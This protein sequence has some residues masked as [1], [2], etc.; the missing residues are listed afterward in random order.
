MASKRILLLLSTISLA[1]APVAVAQISPSNI[2][3]G[4]SQQQR[5]SVPGYSQVTWRVLPTQGMG[6]IDQTGLY[7]S[8]S[9]SGNQSDGIVFI[10]GQP[11]NGPMF[12]TV[13][14]LI[15]GYTPP[16]TV[17]PPQPT[18]PVVSTT[19]PA[20]P[21]T[22]APLQ[23]TISLSPGTVNLQP[24]QSTTFTATVQ[25]TYNTLVQWGVSPSVGTL[26]NGIY[27]APSSI[28]SET[29]VTISA[30]SEADSTQVA[31][32][33]II[34][35]PTVVPV[36]IS[37]TPDSTTLA[38]G[39]SAQ[40]TAS[41]SGTTNTAVNWSLTPSMGSISNGLYTAPSN[42]TSQQTVTL[43]AVSQ[44]DPTKTASASLILKPISKP[45]SAPVTI[46]LSPGSAS[47]LGGQSATFTPSVS[48]TTNKAVTWSI[49][50]QVG[51]ITNGIYQAPAI[52]SSQQIVSI[53]AASVADPSE[54][55]TVTVSL[56][57]IA[58][59][60]TPPTV[61]LGAG[62]SSTF[63]ASVVG[64]SNTAVSW[65]VSP[66]IGTVVN[67]VYTAPATVTS[68]QNV[69]ITATSV[70]DTTKTATATVSLA[71]TPP[72]PTNTTVTLP[73]EVL[74]ANGT[75]VS[76][77]VNIPSGS[78]LSGPMSL[79][80]QIHGLRSE[81]QASVQINNS[82]W[83]PISDSTVTMMGNATAFGGIGGGFHT[84]QMTM[85]LPAGTVQA[86]AN[87]VN[88][89]FN[90][91]D[92]RVSG[93]RVLAFNIQS[94]SGS[95]LIPASTFVEDD[96]STWQPPSSLASDISAGQTL[97][98]TAA[99]TIPS[100][101]GGTTQIRAHC[102]D[103]HAQDG[104]DLKYFNYSNNS[105]QARAVFHGLT[106]AQGNQIA[107]Y[108]RSLNQPNPGLP[109]NPP[110]Q[111]G[112]GLDSQPVTDWAA[113]AGIS[114]VLN[115]DADMLSALMPGGSSASW[116]PNANLSARE[117]PITMQ[118]PD[119]NSWLPGTH[120]MD[121]WPASFPASQLYANYQNIR[122]NLVPNNPSSYTAN[123]FNIWNWTGLDHFGF[124]QTVL[125]S[126]NSSQW[127]NPQY[128]QSIT[129]LEA[130][131][132]TKLWEI[133]QEFGLEGMAQTAFGPQADA[134]AW[135][136][137]EPFFASPGMFAPTG[138]AVGNGLTVTYDY[139]AMSWYHVQLLL[140]ASNNRGTGLG[141]AEDFPYTY[142]HLYHLS[143]EAAPQ[144][145]MQTL[146][147]IKGLQAS[148]NGLGPQAGSGG[149]GLNTNDPY[150]LVWD[151]PMLWDP[152]TS[153]ADQLNVMQSYLTIWLQQVNQF[154]PQ[155]FYRGG[156]VTPTDATTPTLPANGYSSSIAYMIPRFSHYGVS[157]TIM[158]QVIAWAQSIWP[159]YNWAALGT[160]S[161][162][163]TTPDLTCYQ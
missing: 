157:S 137:P 162:A 96:P 117:V 114:A 149:W 83:M 91:T 112:P 90:Q 64:T 16:V 158:N 22:V 77:T 75:T 153:P 23:I 87:T 76:A 54:T 80:M 34:L 68:A 42:L 79:Y 10:Y 59:T 2:F 33:T 154:T 52:V 104:R 3:M 122:A 145:L 63:S 24:G 140:N 148:Q 100:T 61:S 89:R 67:G 13:V 65:S 78:N 99:L 134:R 131:S 71:A 95:Q 151:A 92:G 62:A 7:T 49:S 48:G 116:G 141:P 163:A 109:W 123:K 97:W 115:H 125:V 57:S 119:W 66:A 37:V 8:P 55:A 130:W 14:W 30:T 43:T 142:N 85:N 146:W 38:G 69:T 39:Q 21:T 53:T 126:P 82:S 88:F 138:S 41:V 129:S 60:L 86:G 70:A 20:P 156:W 106:A 6:T 155:E 9:L 11:A 32:A 105:I 108:I 103:C 26:N 143:V 110:Y 101:S 4:S 56:T 159:Y 5:F 46:S 17:A 111:P 135:Y 161:C 84:F 127:N 120:P 47:L 73:L 136:S 133:N 124:L 94:A 139:D 102:M 18:P 72:P 132:M 35:A 1:L 121:L 144:A 40:F 31:T 15:P 29:Q 25:G 81:T 98:R 44:A 150:R 58:V 51:S 128:V 50:P 74:G 107:S 45:V 36:G 152:N 19:P 160:E 147:L 113:G 12:T 27:T 118:L 93:F 28:A